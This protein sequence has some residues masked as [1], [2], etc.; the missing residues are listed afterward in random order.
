MLNT[1]SSA[2]Q[3]RN[4]PCGRS[5]HSAL[6]YRPSAL[7]LP[8]YLLQPCGSIEF[9]F[10]FWRFRGITGYFFYAFSL[11][12]IVIHFFLFLFRAL[13]LLSSLYVPKRLRLLSTVLSRTLCVSS[14]FLKKLNS[15]IWPMWP[16]LY[17][18]VYS[19]YCNSSNL[20]YSVCQPLPLKTQ[21][22]PGINY[23]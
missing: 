7:L 4:Q 13:L 18:P 16:K 8:S 12:Y 3:T 15:S 21:L 17:T 2:I 22:L 5:R 19:Y 14:P 10:L 23:M 20:C 1:H 9:S 6:S 11:C